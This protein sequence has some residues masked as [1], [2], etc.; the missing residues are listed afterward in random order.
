M[1]QSRFA[2]TT[3]FIVVAVVALLIATDRA[4]RAP[5]AVAPFADPAIVQLDP[6]PS[7]W[8]FP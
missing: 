5:S 3:A 8:G 1:L 4:A 7:F 2:E 6:A